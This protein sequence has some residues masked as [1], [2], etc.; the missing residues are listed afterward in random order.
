MRWTLLQ[1]FL[2]M[3]TITKKPF[4]RGK[5]LDLLFLQHPC[6]LKVRIYAKTTTTCTLPNMFSTLTLQSLEPLE[7]IVNEI[8]SSLTSE[9]LSEADIVELSRKAQKNTYIIENNTAECH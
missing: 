2:E 1:F 3:K 5:Q 8:P 9:S 4:H 7:S 6:L